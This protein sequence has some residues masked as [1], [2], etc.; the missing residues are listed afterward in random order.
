MF[1]VQWS[2]VITKRNFLVHY[3][4]FNT[5]HH[6]QRE[7]DVTS[8]GVILSSDLSQINKHVY[9]SRELRNNEKKTFGSL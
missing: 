8:T 3:S 4:D 6:L 1:T 2:Y 7:S 9:F 5:C